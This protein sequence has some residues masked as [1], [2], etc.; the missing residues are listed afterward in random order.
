MAGVPVAMVIEAAGFL[1]HTGQFD[2]ARAH[3]LDV[4]LRGCVSILE[5]PLF[6][7]LAPEDLVVAVAVERR[8][9]VDQ[10]HAAVGKFA[11]LAEVVAAV[12][13]ARVDERRRTSGGSDGFAGGRS[14]RELGHSSSFPLR[15][16]R[17]RRFSHA[18]LSGFAS[19]F[20]RHIESVPNARRTRQGDARFWRPRHAC[21]NERLFHRDAL[22]EVAG[23]IDVAAA[24]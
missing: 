11:K 12:D 19:G 21:G 20:S 8:V 13:D 14:G 2:T 22:G 16:Y 3:V 4:R 1:E 7:G 18:R 23:F 6:L 15:W 9:D 24:T 5:G 17:L 10:V